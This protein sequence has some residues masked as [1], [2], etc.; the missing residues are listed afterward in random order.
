[1]ETITNT[2]PLRT[3]TLCFDRSKVASK[4]ETYT[5]RYYDEAHN[6]TWKR[7]KR[8]QRARK[9]IPKYRYWIEGIERLLDLSS[10]RFD[11]L[12]RMDTANPARETVYTQLKD[13]LNEMDT[14]LNERMPGLVRKTEQFIEYEDHCLQQ[15]EW[16]EKVAFPQFHEL[17]AQH[18]GCSVHKVFFDLDLESFRHELAFVKKQETL[19]LDEMDTLTNDFTDLSY[20][21]EHLLEEVLEFDGTLFD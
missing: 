12:K 9:P 4:F 10:Y 8:V 2:H 3:I 5:L 19:Y 17:L 18:E 15:D 13:L 16:M 1:M 20:R 14:H 7:L 6:R 11:R 21:I